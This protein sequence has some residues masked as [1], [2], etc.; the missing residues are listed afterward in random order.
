[1]ESEHCCIHTGIRSTLHRKWTL[2]ACTHGHPLHGKW[3][4][5]SCKIVPMGIRYMESEHCMLAKLYPRASVTWK[6]DTACLQNCT[7]GH[8]LHGKWTLHACKIVP[9]GI[10]YMESA[11]TLHTARGW[12]NTCPCCNAL[13]STQHVS[14]TAVN[15][16]TTR[17]S[18]H[19]MWIFTI[20]KLHF[21]HKNVRRIQI[22]MTVKIRLIK[23][24]VNS[25]LK[26][27]KLFQFQNSVFPTVFN[28]CCSL[29]QRLKFKYQQFTQCTTGRTWN[30]LWHTAQLYT[31][32]S[33]VWKVHG[34]CILH[35]NCTHGHP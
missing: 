29:L 24:K 15:V 3:T 12:F 6:V 18:M 1:M 8:P 25:P 31:R 19:K 27:T 34:H 10:R 16:H 14:G 21:H 5:H 28:G 9:T 30:I 23:S 7:H 22:Q 13:N 26:I 2:H 35:N 4:L 33:V 32:A 20:L 17:N 11:W